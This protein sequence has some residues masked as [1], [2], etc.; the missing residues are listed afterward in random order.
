M[1]GSD[2]VAGM[3][4]LTHAEARA[5]AECITVTSMHVAL[6][7]S[8]QDVP[9]PSFDS[10]T[11]INFTA[12]EGGQ[13]FLDFRGRRLVKATV[14]GVPVDSSCWADGRIPLT[15]LRPE[16]TVIIEGEMDYS[17]DGE[18]LHRHLDPADERIYLY[19]MSFLDAA[20]RWFA[21]FDQ[22]D[23]KAGYILDVRA[24]SGWTV[25]GNG[26]AERINDG[27]RADG[28]TDWRII[29]HRPLASYF[30]TLIAGPYASIYRELAGTRAGIHV[31]ASLA[32][33]LAA[34][35][36]DIF[37]VTEQCLD[38]Y[39]DAFAI[40]Y[41]FGEYHQ[42]FVPDFNAGAMENPGCVT[43]RDSFIYRSRATRAERAARA[44]V[45]AHEM[46]HQWFGDLVTMRWWDELWLNESFAEYLGRRSCTDIGTYPLWTEFGINRK[47]WGYVED[48]SPNT[49]P[50]AGNG[51][52]DAQSAL[53]NFDGI[54]YAK[55]AA[56][57]RQLAGYLGD[58][59]FWAGLRRYLDGYA[60]GNAEF[61]QLLDCWTAAGG[62]DLPGWSREWLATA[63]VDTLLVDRRDDTR[64]VTRQVPDGRPADRQHA[65]EIAG[66]A[67]DGRLIGS[68]RVVLGQDGL[69]MTLGDESVAVLPDV[70]DETWAKIRF[71]RHDW[72]VITD[73][74]SHIRSPQTRTMI[75]N[76][77]QDQV[78]DADL[79]PAEALQT[80]CD[81]LPDESEDVITETMLGFAAR[82]IASRFVG[83]PDRAQRLRQVHELAISILRSSAPGS[84][85]QLIG[86]RAAIATSQDT[87]QLGR[88]W[89]RRGLPTGIELDPDLV[90]SLVTRLCTLD[91][92]SEAITETLATD[93]TAAAQT[94]AAG[95]RAALPTPEAKGAAYRILTEPSDLTAYQI[96][97]TAE[98]MFPATADQ[99]DLTREYALRFFDDIADTAAFRS[100]WL[101][102]R[103]P[104]LG[105]PFAVTEQATLERAEAA[106]ARPDV[107]DAVSRALAGGADQLRRALTAI[108]RF[109]DTA[110]PGASPRGSKSTGH[111]TQHRGHGGNSGDL[112]GTV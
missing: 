47:N 56:V 94:R 72:N 9:D 36:D 108:E 104:L 52:A 111:P 90:W 105:F 27:S 58:D 100:G 29:Q 39:H 51:A 75:W 92:H 31:R 98:A 64:M 103:V 10:V 99:V 5:R 19:A 3:P 41:P 73:R 33:E 2:N 68:E 59:V 67:A 49:H 65:T 43:F 87:G 61:A 21:C 84:D 101:L 6:D 40:G 74:L 71:G 106:I 66:L 89:R 53:T 11:T 62:I 77:L 79:A 18:G 86:F 95:A 54:S 8:R 24:P 45:I 1:A 69:P 85:R 37:A 91:D 93:H 76:S 88:W 26:P 32:D 112:S 96:Y 55:G 30:V 34:E 82:T 81:Q 7:L 44:G 50:V 23:L 110:G 109:T 35:A 70:A 57:L 20:P 63:G 102:N 14:N 13:T 48:Q 83:V 16:N 80:I 28:C 12:V 78:R 25:H 42:A 107:G 97:A 22:P 60:F 46:A 4:S 15:G 17:S 38:Y